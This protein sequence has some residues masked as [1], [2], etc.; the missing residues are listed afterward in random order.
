[1]S[2]LARERWRRATGEMLPD[3]EVNGDA[4]PADLAPE[5]AQVPVAI[6]RT[7]PGWRDNVAV[8]EISPLTVDMIR[9]G[10]HAIY[11]EAQYFTA[12]CI[13]GVLEQS[14][15]ASKGPEI[16][17]VVTR[18]AHS[19]LER[20]F[21]GENRDRLIR[22]LRRADRH[23]RF[24][25][26]Y[27]VVPGE[28][29]ACNVLLHSKVMIVDDHLVR[30]GSANLN[31][32]SMGLDTECD[33]VIE[34]HDAPSRRAVTALRARLLGEHAGVAPD[35][36]QEAVAR[37]GSLIRALDAVG[38]GARG[39][40]PYPE[41]KLGGPVN[42]RV[43]TFLADP[44]RPFEPWWWRRRKRFRRGDNAASARSAAI[45]AR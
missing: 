15:L 38:R 30:I 36:L 14:L 29:G 24:R 28:K 1:M 5:F 19:M 42:S 10:R 6:A 21:L 43:G 3:T 44:T 45:Q 7:E 31:N 17:V 39:L 27:P 33:L 18:E 4:W 34:A 11:I 9:A 40:R 20:V 26:Y 22:R 35:E 37:Q 32:R 23:N 12:R 41:I 13:R 25:A 2:V 8:E 16:I